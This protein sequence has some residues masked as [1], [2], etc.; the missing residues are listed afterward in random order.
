MFSLIGVG[1][2]SSL[3]LSFAILF[4]PQLGIHG[5]Y[6]EGTTTL[7]FFV[8]LG[9]ILEDKANLKTQS[10]LHE[11][12]NLSPQKALRVD[13]AGNDKEVPVSLLTVGS[14]LRV[15][16]GAQV[17]L[18]GEIIEGSSAIDESLISGEFIPVEKQVGDKV[19]GGTLNGLGS[20][21]MRVE[22]TG[23][24][25]LI[26]KMV[27]SVTE[28]Q[29]QKIPIQ[30]TADKASAIFTPWV[31]LIAALTGAF[32]FFLGNENQLINSITQAV[33][34][35]MIACPCALGLATPISILVGTTKGAKSGVLF[36]KLD[37][38][39]ELEKIDT[40]VF[41]KTGTLTE[42]KPKLTSFEVS[43]GNSKNELL[44]W[45]GSLE[46]ASEHPFAKAVLEFC[47]VQGIRDF[48]KVDGF[49]SFPGRGIEGSIEGNLIQIGNED[50]MRALGLLDK[51]I[52]LNAQKNREQGETTFFVAVQKKPVAVMGLK[53]P[54]RSD[55]L[56]TIQ[57]F[58]NLGL[59]LKLLSG[60]HPTITKQT[61]E[62]LGIK[63][64]EGGILP[65]EKAKAIQNL[66][67]LG[68]K[69]AF[70]GDG[71]NDAPAL[72]QADVGIA[73]GTGTDLAKQTAGITLLKGDV[74]SASHA[75]SL[76][77]AMMKNIRQNLIWAFSY[78]LVGIP[79]AAGVFYPHFGIKLT[80]VFSS[81]AMTLSSL[82][83]VGNSLRLRFK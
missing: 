31:F 20:F 64:W 54:L 44:R 78:N 62:A 73:M 63:D 1:V 3:G 10:A 81:L 28:A 83:V 75:F 45:I 32:W 41:D 8:L 25:T 52:F 50:W 5:F 53:D 67:K 11:L 48:I 22:K 43:Q 4:F 13:K 57:S 80:P 56:E 61:A 18:D 39:Q 47:Q 36:Q 35:L 9:Q 79:L 37:A 30:K 27:R 16:P 77:R 46:K 74:K 65:S 68:R 59:N 7:V 49:K 21:L 26:S 40:L 2:F 17:P 71:I 6:F 82:L 34:V 29:S 72:S 19:T 55:V 76:S 51:N 66:Q 70:M 60:D 33:S 42:G 24:E 58:Q 15:L 14:V 12:L 38:I 23:E 69:V